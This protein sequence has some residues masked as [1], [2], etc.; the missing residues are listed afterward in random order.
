MGQGDP[1]KV[2]EYYAAHQEGHIDRM[3]GYALNCCEKIRFFYIFLFF[4]LF[5]FIF[6]RPK[7]PEQF[8]LIEN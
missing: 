2:R 4:C 3:L 1:E 5:L 8:F 6:E 7:Y